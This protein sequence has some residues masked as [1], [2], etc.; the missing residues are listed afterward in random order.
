MAHV[1]IKAPHPELGGKAQLILNGVDISFD[2]MVSPFVID[3][4]DPSE[5]RKPSVVVGIA[6]DSLDIDV[7]AA[8]LDALAVDDRTGE[9]V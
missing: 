1:Q 5:G 8:V 4:G 2:L 9:L 6:C 3:F 7:P